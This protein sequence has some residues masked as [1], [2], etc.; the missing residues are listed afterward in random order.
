[1]ILTGNEIKK[2]IEKGDIVISPFNE[3][4]LNPNSYNLKLG[5]WLKKYY[6]NDYI[7]IKEKPYTEDV[8]ILDTG[9][10]LKPGELYLGSTEEYT[11]TYDL[12]P[13]IEGR[14]SVGRLGISVH[15]SNGFGDIGFKGNWTLCITATVPV[16]IYPHIEICQI[17]YSEI[18]GE[19]MLYTSEKYQNSEGINP[20]KLYLDLKK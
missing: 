1:M 9:Y 6:V 3:S 20:S 15:C 7:D 12:V 18:S 11:E 5:N 2:R 10:M 19:P 16:I 17:Y 8:K 14:S 13:R 4:Q